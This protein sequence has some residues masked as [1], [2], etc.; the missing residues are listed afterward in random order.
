MTY[1]DAARKLKALG[2]HEIPRR[3]PG[4][5]RKWV[6]PR[7][8]RLTILPDWGAKDLKVGTLHGAIRQL[9]LNWQDFINA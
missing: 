9:E 5:H 2:C 8:N 3:G 4:S 1:R 6:N 7:T